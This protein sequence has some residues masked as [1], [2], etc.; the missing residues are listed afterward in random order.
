MLT[1]Y[2]VGRLTRPGRRLVDAAT[3]LL[4]VA[5]CAYAA[6]TALTGPAGTNGGVVAGR[7]ICVVAPAVAAVIWTVRLLRR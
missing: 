7:T 2:R 3:I 4:T 5:L 1:Y 6:T